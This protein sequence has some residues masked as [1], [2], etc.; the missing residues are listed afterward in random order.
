MVALALHVSCTYARTP[1]HFHVDC[2]HGDDSA[3]GLVRDESLRTVHAAQASVRSLRENDTTKPTPAVVHITGLCELKTVLQFDAKDNNVIYIGDGEGAILSAGTQLE[4]THGDE[5]GLISI[6]LAKYN[7]SADNLGKL[8]GRGYSGGSACILLNR[9]ESSA[10]ELFYRPNSTRSTASA[11]SVSVEDMDTMRLA[12]FP[13]VASGGLPSDA[14]W[15]K[16]S[17]VKDHTLGLNG[18]T[19]AQLASWGQEMAAGSDAWMHGLWAWNWA[20]SHRPITSVGIDSLVVGDDDAGDADVAPIKAGS[21]GG[22]GGNVYAYNLRSELDQEGEYYIDRQKAT[23][24][25]MPIGGAGSSSSGSRGS[26]FL[27]RLEAVVAVSGASNITLQNLEIRHSRGGGVVV[28]DSN[29]FLVKDC[30]VANNGMMGINITGGT[31][32]GVAESEISG[33]GD[34]GVIMMGGDRTTLTPA[35]HFVRNC[36]LHHNQRFI[37]NYAPH[38]FLGGVGQ[39]V[40]GSEI[41]AAPQIGVFMQGNDHTLSSSNLHHL[42]QQCSDCGAFYMGR[43]W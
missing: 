15:L 13:N 41:F 9:F 5:N 8:K 3:T 34:G 2:Q 10:A 21:S 19:P 38:V 31:N 40:E 17:T 42:A 6:D 37:M 26:Y 28:T 25:F 32:C 11:R 4:T 7:F 20:D 22:Q 1:V 16:I 29:G 27:S 14:D 33:N 30:T 18:V 24:D 43:E 36:S 23:L 12:R 35:G 39:S